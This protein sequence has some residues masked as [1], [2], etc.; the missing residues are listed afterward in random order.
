MPLAVRVSL[1]KLPA[2]PGP[3]PLP[4]TRN[5]HRQPRGAGAQTQR[6][7]GCFEACGIPHLVASAPTSWRGSP[8][9]GGGAPGRAGRWGALGQVGEPQERLSGHDFP[10]SQGSV[11]VATRPLPTA[12]A[13]RLFG[14]VRGAAKVTVEGPG[15]QPLRLSP[16]HVRSRCHIGGA[17]EVGAATPLQR[18]TAPR[19]GQVPV[20]L[21]GLPRG[22][23]PGLQ[24][25]ALPFTP[26]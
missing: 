21:R 22:L 5:T 3:L 12:S 19:P 17:R 2:R 4:V 9:G 11:A 10:V 1:G 13:R 20:C 15:A 26:S 7:V 23:I 16:Q 6:E 8:G 14:A 18:Q 24:G 25:Q